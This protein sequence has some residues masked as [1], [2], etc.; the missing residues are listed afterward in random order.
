MRKSRSPTVSRA[1]RREPA[2]PPGR[3]SGERLR[4]VEG[5]PYPRG[6]VVWAHIYV[7]VGWPVFAPKTW[8]WAEPTI[9][10]APLGWD[11]T[12]HME[13]TGQA[14]LPELG[15]IA[16]PAAQGGQP[17]ATVAGA[18]AAGASQ[19][20]LFETVIVSVTTMVLATAIIDYLRAKKAIPTPR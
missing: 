9:R 18:S 13:R 10:N 6:T 2:D 14:S 16:S 15:D 11:V 4:W 3:A 17:P 19:K 12:S 5:T 1:R 8:A 7:T 20:S